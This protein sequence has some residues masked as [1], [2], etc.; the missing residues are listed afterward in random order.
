MKIKLLALASA[1]VMTSLAICFVDALRAC[2]GTLPLSNPPWSCTGNLV[3][4]SPYQWVV[5]ASSGWSSAINDG[6]QHCNYFCW[7]YN[8]DHTIA[9]PLTGSAYTG[10][11]TSGVSC[12]GS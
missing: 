10:A 8:E 1:G 7:A 9:V 11:Y 12:P 5:T 3:S 2:P 6:V 4:G